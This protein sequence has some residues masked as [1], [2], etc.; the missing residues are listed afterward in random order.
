MSQ[1][2]SISDSVFNNVR[3]AIQETQT[4]PV[5]DTNAGEFLGQRDGGTD[6]P[7]KRSRAWCFTIFPATGRIPDDS[8]FAAFNDLYSSC[9]QIRY[10][11][12]GRETCPTTDR[13]HYQGY[14]YFT[15]VKS[16]TYLQSLLPWAGRFHCE[17][18]RGSPESN[19]RYCTKEGDYIE[20]GE[21]PRKGNR[22]DLGLLAQEI[23]SGKSIETVATEYPSEFIRYHGGIKAFHHLTHSKARNSAVPVTVHWWFGPTGVGKS[24]KAFETFGDSAYIKMNDKWWDGYAGQNIVIFDDYRPNLCP[25]NELLRILDRYPFRVQ[26]KGSSMELSAT[27][28]VI[29]TTSRP[30]ALWHSRTD[31]QIGQLLRRISNIIQFTSSPLGTVETILKDSTTVYVPLSR[32]ELIALFPSV[33]EQKMIF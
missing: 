27:T 3:A 33:P 8:K 25:F 24:R 30:E 18:A 5:H 14:I 12:V 1:E 17:A 13:Q 28:F 32:E 4:E 16:R 31:E 11:C 19:Q 29:T 6:D 15:C 2:N 7:K 21:L 22:S 9:K 10:L 23:I 26:L 20:H